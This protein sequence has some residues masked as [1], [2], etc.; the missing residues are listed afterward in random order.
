MIVVTEKAKWRNLY[1]DEHTFRKYL[2]TAR[3]LNWNRVVGLKQQNLTNPK[4]H[5]KNDFTIDPSSDKLPDKNSSPQ[6][7]WRSVSQHSNSLPRIAIE[8]S[9]PCS[10]KIIEKKT[11]PG[12]IWRS[13]S[14]NL[15]PLPRI[16]FKIIDTPDRNSSRSAKTM[17]RSLDDVRY[18]LYRT[19]NEAKKP[20]KNRKKNHRK[21]DVENAASSEVSVLTDPTNSTT[22]V[23]DEKVRTKKKKSRKG[24]KKGQKGRFR[25][26]PVFA[27]TKYPTD[28][29]TPE[30]VSS[31]IADDPS[32]MKN[33]ILSNKIQEEAEEESTLKSMEETTVSKLEDLSIRTEIN[34]STKEEDEVT[35]EGEVN[36][37]TDS[38]FVSVKDESL[39][40]TESSE[41][42]FV[43]EDGSVEEA[44]VTTSTSTEQINSTD[45]SETTNWNWYSE[46]DLD[47]KLNFTG[48]EDATRLDSGERNTS[49]ISGTKYSLGEKLYWRWKTTFLEETTVPD[50]ENSS[51][52]TEKST[53]LQDYKTSTVLSSEEILIADRSSQDSTETSDSRKDSEETTYY[54]ENLEEKGSSSVSSTASTIADENYSYNVSANVETLLFESNLNNSKILIDLLSKDRLADKILPNSIDQTLEAK[55]YNCTSKCVDF[56]RQRVYELEEKLRQAGIEKSLTSENK[57]D[58]GLIEDTTLS[59]PEDDGNSSDSFQ[60][61]SE[62]SEVFNHSL[63]IKPID[64]KY[65]DATESLT[66]VET[67]TEL[68]RNDISKESK[69]IIDQEEG[70]DQQSKTYSRIDDVTV[71]TSLPATKSSSSP[72]RRKCKK[73]EKTK[74]RADQDVE[75]DCEEDMTERPS[76][77]NSDLISKETS[78]T[79]NCDPDQFVCSDGTCIA[80]DKWCDGY[81]DCPD[82]GDEFD[83]NGN[84]NGDYENGV[85]ET[86]E[87]STCPMWKFACDGTCIDNIFVCNSV[88]DC[89]DGLD[90]ADCGMEG[91]NQSIYPSSVL[92]FHFLASSN[93][94]Q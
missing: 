20:K 44:V 41:K 26:M 58:S 57:I 89:E 12:N 64:P 27:G 55:I 22:V 18:V 92:F 35:L 82:Y 29:T 2:E 74:L 59:K 23:N 61:F 1:N 46:E 30:T 34:L 76:T 71:S 86:E 8:I 45:F 84:T 11:N 39:I 75:D 13:T 5:P 83:C 49:D 4:K 25:H 51:W 10:M 77:T 85:N 9:D 14:R 52:T 90:E 68:G 66:L 6:N 79:A 17:I 40:L 7:I 73:D 65:S 87:N 28:S 81:S 37:T 94:L 24:R 54:D 15:S 78:T 50:S 93:I 91:R 36:R 32:S 47:K 63:T 43:S 70:Q 60:D 56:Y 42:L 19:D 72:A 21:S 69:E 3:M 38:V 62:F 53:E 48:E 16:G 88:K 31:T 80:A 33:E 67:V